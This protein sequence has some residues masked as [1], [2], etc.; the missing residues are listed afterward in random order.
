MQMLS[1]FLM[2]VMY[3]LFALGFVFVFAFPYFG[4][5]LYKKISLSFAEYRQMK[6][7]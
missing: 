2:G 4:F 5:K 7:L 1:F 3:G 6:G